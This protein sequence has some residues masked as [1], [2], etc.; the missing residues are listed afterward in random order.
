MKKE[1]RFSHRFMEEKWPSVSKKTQKPKF[2]MS[3][4]TTFLSHLFSIQLRLCVEEHPWKKASI[5][6][7]RHDRRF[8][9]RAGMSAEWFRVIPQ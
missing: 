2:M 1:F 9:T 4:R 7:S 8:Q 6:K 5:S 3:N